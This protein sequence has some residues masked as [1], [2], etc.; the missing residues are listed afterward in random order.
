MF[1]VT[2][3]YIRPLEELDVL[4]DAHMTWLRKHYESGLFL[5]SGR[6]VPRRGGVIFARSGERA[7]LEAVLARDP[8]VQNGVATTEVIEFVPSMTAPATEILKTV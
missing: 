7:A 4:M 5:A 8:F 6:Q 3:T 1:I 2:L